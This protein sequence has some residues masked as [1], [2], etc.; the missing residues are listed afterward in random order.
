MNKTVKI[1]LDETIYSSHIF[2]TELIETIYKSY[3]ILYVINKNKNYINGETRWYDGTNLR[4]RLENE[5][6]KFAHKNHSCEAYFDDCECE[7][8][9]NRRKV[10]S[11]E[12]KYVFEGKFKFDAKK[13]NEKYDNDDD[14]NDENNICKSK[15][16]D[17]MLLIKKTNKKIPISNIKFVLDKCINLQNVNGFNKGHR[18]LDHMI[19]KLPF[20]SSIKLSKEFTLEEMITSTY[21]LKSHKF[22]YWYELFCD[23]KIIIDDD[24]IVVCLS[25]DHGS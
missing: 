14:E 20:E 25:F 13:F 19:I 17:I 7:S 8:K 9:L 18:G 15:I 5:G 2:W 12:I 4:T 21:N 24:E 10:N 6:I 16:K 11:N 1:K 23:T 3:E 22:D